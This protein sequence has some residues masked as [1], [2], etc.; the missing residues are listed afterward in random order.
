MTLL[1]RNLERLEALLALHLAFGAFLVPRSCALL[2][3][4][5]ESIFR[6]LQPGTHDFL[7]LNAGPPV[8][9]NV[10]SLGTRT[11]VA[12]LNMQQFKNSN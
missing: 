8:R 10:K 6:T 11:R 5:E 3:A 12:A 9:I 4:A 7:G 2:S 1:P